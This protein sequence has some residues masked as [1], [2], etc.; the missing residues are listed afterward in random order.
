MI[1][2]WIQEEDIKIVII[3]APDLEAL[4]HIRQMIFFLHK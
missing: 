2:G 4:Q 3:Y 1:K